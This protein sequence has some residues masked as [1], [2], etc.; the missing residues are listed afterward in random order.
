MQKSDEN[1]NDYLYSHFLGP[2]LDESPS[3][4]TNLIS[5]N[6]D[7]PTVVLVFFIGGCTFAEVHPF[8]IHYILLFD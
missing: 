5:N 8:K 2:T 3:V 6:S 1:V 4:S 7:S